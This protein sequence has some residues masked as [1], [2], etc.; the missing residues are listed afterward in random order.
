MSMDVG[1]A[2][3]CYHEVTVVLQGYYYA[4]VQVALRGFCT[5]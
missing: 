2:R 5:Y 4:A 1:I 3:V